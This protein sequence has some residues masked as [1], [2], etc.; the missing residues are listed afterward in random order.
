MTAGRVVLGVLLVGIGTVFLLDTA[1]VIESGDAVAV[2]WPA[3]LVLLGG[4]QIGIERRVSTVSGIVVVVGVVALLVTTGAVDADLWALVWPIL[5]IGA[6]LWLVIRRRFP[7]LS[8]E[9]AISRLAVLAPDRLASRAPAFSRGDIT[10]I[11]TTMRLDLTKAELAPDGAQLAATAVFGSVV[12]VVPKGWKV[13]IRGV[14]VF[15]G[16]DDTTSRIDVGPDAPVVR[17]SFLTLFGGIEVR[18][19]RRW[20]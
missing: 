1:N 20:R 8:K 6:G 2:W 5:L 7:P 10:A 12:V 17:I 18:H 16:F 13:V 9:N 19:P 11:L 14:P 15:G 4:A 3:I